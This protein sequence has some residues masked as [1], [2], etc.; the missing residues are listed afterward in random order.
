M[1]AELRA[2]IKDPRAI[3]LRL[4]KLGAKFLKK[5]SLTD[6]Y[7]GSLGLYEKLNHSFWLRVR[8]EGKRTVLAYKGSTGKDGV[9]EEYEQEVQNPKVIIKILQKAGFDNPI[10]VSKK[11][12]SYKLGDINIEIDK[13]ENEGSYIELE[14]NSKNHDKS[15][16]Y[17]LFDK[18][19]IPKKDIFEIG[20]ITR[21]LKKKKTPYT[22]WIKN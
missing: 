15:P 17:E 7:F 22:K 10:T 21:F 8:I 14:I 1:E 11:R 2:K 9:Y 5:R 20:Y 3:E 16:L 13:F 12:T 18:L 4:K 19:G 6:Y